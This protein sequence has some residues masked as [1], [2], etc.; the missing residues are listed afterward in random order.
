MGRGSTCAVD[1]RIQILQKTAV[2]ESGTALRRKRHKHGHALQIR[3][4]LRVHT[5][6]ESSRAEVDALRLL[7]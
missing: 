1:D 4:W 2:R 7:R 3:Q 6:R 5:A